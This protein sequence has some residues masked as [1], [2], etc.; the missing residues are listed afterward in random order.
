MAVSIV[1]VLLTALQY[2]MHLLKVPGTVPV[3]VPDAVSVFVAIPEAIP[4]CK[5]VPVAVPAP[6]EV[7]VPVQVTVPVPEAV[8][9]AVPKTEPVSIAVAVPEAVPDTIAVPKKV[10]HAVPETVPVPESTPMVVPITRGICSTS[11]NTRGGSSSREGTKGSTSDNWRCCGAVPI[12]EVLSLLSYS[13][14][15]SLISAVCEN[16]REGR[17]ATINTV[18]TFI[19]ER[20]IP[21]LTTA[22]PPPLSNPLFRAH[23]QIDCANICAGISTRLN[24]LYET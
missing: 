23:M 17:N 9:V 13:R 6:E 20:A 22:L 1:E 4:V 12:P 7:L 15:S 2:Q 3:A 11:F 21:W 5:A 10:P 16:L 8:L 19:R 18:N 24:K 14:C